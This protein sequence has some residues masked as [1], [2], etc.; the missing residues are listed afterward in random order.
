MA[1]SRFG[2][3]F[4][5]FVVLLIK[6]YY[7]TAYRVR[8]WGRLPWNRGSTLVLANHQHDLDTTMPIIQ[9]QWQGPWDRP[10]YAAAS[11]RMFDPGFLT[12]RIPW[13]S[14]TLHGFDATKLF[15]ALGLTPIENEIRTRSVARMARFVYVRHG[16]MP[17]ANVF[18]SDVIDSLGSQAAD[19][20]IAQLFSPQWF[21]RAEALRLPLKVLLE[22]YRSEI[23][24]D[25]RSHIEPDYE[26]LEALLRSGNTLF[27]TPEAH[28]SADG[29]TRPL[30]AALMRLR[31]SAQE[32]ALVSIS[33]DPFVS[34][35]FSCLFR[36]ATPM[37]PNNIEDSM[38]AARP[39]TVSQLLA[40]FMTQGSQDTF[41]RDQAANAV[42]A[43]LASLP[44]A[45]FVDPQLRRRPRR[46]TLAAI[47]AM[48]RRGILHDESGAL[49]L[50]SQRTH[51][52]YPHVSDIVAFQA[53]YFSQ[54]LHALQT[55]DAKQGHTA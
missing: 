20:K 55:L 8:S 28:Y 19:L 15:T 31:P 44:R 53:S 27:L 10:I 6:P 17:V 48:R 39:I 40:A 1:R 13:L 49:H 2:F 41:T 29:T 24:E 5:T 21:E 16:D 50:T 52:Q 7:W 36:I 18:R 35:R 12:T 22:P 54:T 34:G 11:R 32:T 51:P 46:V 33:Y 23:L 3:C 25:T 47:E 26:R 42:I 4:Q 9:L 38:R 45:A 30:L 14:K 43:Y 37:D